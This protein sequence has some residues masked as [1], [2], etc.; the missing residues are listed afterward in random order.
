MDLKRY[1]FKIVFF[2]GQFFV[3]K[4]EGQ[5]SLE[6]LLK[7]MEYMGNLGKNWNTWEKLEYLRKIWEKFEYL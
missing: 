4:S 5:D 7:K 1:L 2:L 3:V 6:Y